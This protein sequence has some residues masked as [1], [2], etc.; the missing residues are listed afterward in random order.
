M[1]ECKKLINNPEKLR[2]FIQD[3]IEPVPCK[4]A[5]NCTK[6]CLCYQCD[7]LPKNK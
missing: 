7:E 4:Q 5:T 6:D 2:T 3:R 1:N